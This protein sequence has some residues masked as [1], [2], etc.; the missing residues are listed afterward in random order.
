MKPRTKTTGELEKLRAQLAERDERLRDLEARRALEQEDA[1][2]ATYHVS[3]EA[4][5]RLAEQESALGSAR[6]EMKAL[7]GRVI[8]TEAE[9]T[10][11]KAELTRVQTASTQV[12]AELTCVRTKLQHSQQESVEIAV[13]ARSLL[14]DYMQYVHNEIHRPARRIFSRLHP[15]KHFRHRKF[16][17][18]LRGSAYFDAEWY[19]ARNADVAESGMDP[20][21]HFIEYGFPEGRAPNSRFEEAR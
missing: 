18:R 17:E 9:L 15:L 2:L 5:N 11:V 20:A 7:R 4:S 13:Q 8:E 6:R 12:E 10:R 14:D 3:L 16:V 19:L 1:R 21:L